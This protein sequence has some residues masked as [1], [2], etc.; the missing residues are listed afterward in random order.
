[1]LNEI[2]LIERALPDDKQSIFMRLLN[3]EDSFNSQISFDLFKICLDKFKTLSTPNEEICIHS[4]EVCKDLIK[5]NKDSNL[6]EVAKNRMIY[7]LQNIGEVKDEQ[8]NFSK[9]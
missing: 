5:N 6:L 1:M 4:L 7:F 2:N 9:I 3:N 8:K